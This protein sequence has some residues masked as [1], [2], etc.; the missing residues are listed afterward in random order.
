MRA[1]LRTLP[2]THD[3]VRDTHL[4]FG[5]V[6]QPLAALHPEDEPVPLARSTGLDGPVRCNRCKGYI[7]PACRFTDGG[8]KF[9]CNLCGFENN[10]RAAR[11]YRAF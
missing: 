10:G 9:V 4:P 2:K 8:R 1:T 7:N 5:L 3:L 11:S 6:V